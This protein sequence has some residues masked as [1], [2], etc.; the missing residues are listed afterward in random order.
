M[1][2]KYLKQILAVF[3]PFYKVMLHCVDTRR[4]FNVDTTLHDIVRRRIDVETTSCVYGDTQ[5][6][7]PDSTFLEK[8]FRKIVVSV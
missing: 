4:C 8:S 3:K 7:F 2:S 5:S 6:Y 1:D